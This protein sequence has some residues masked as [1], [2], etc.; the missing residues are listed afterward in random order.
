MAR[1]F[2]VLRSFLSS[3]RF[4]K[5]RFP[6]RVLRSPGSLC[7]PFNFKEPIKNNIEWPIPKA[8]WTDHS[9][10]NLNNRFGERIEWTALLN[11]LRSFLSGVP[12]TGAVREGVKNRWATFWEKLSKTWEPGKNS[13]SL[14]SRWY[15]NCGSCSSTG[16]FRSRT[17]KSGM[18][19][20]TGSGT[21]G[22]GF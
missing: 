10:K 19:G 1:G 15:S 11:V 13:N 8:I 20:R 12:G 5:S 7:E 6:S 2:Q 21:D 9:E 16:L 18:G 4:Y 14:R 3:L 22:L 17:P